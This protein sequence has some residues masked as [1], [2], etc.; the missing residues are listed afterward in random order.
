MKTKSIR[1]VNLEL[2]ITLQLTCM[3]ANLLWKHAGIDGK[4]LFSL[5]KPDEVLLKFFRAFNF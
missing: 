5:F 3:Q 4:H 2:Q 1:H